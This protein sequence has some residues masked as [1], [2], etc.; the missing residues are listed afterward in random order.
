[1]PQSRGKLKPDYFRKKRKPSSIL[2]CLLNGEAWTFFPGEDFTC[3]QKSF[4]TRAR[5]W[6]RKHTEQNQGL[7]NKLEGDGS[8]TLQLYELSDAEI[9]WRKKLAERM[10]TSAAAGK[11]GRPRQKPRPDQPQP[12]PGQRSAH[13]AAPQAKAPPQQRPQPPRP[14]QGQ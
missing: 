12:Q 9:Q 13:D 3:S 11:V 7:A 14:P 6:V 8:V 1:M 2:T 10:R 5:S 4:L